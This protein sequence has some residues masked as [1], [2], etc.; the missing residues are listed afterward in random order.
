MKSTIYQ[1]TKLRHNRSSLEKLS[2]LATHIKPC[3]Y[4][5][6]KRPGKTCKRQGTLCT[7][8]SYRPTSMWTHKRQRHSSYRQRT[9]FYKKMTG[10]GVMESLDNI[11]SAR[12]TMS[13]GAILQLCSHIQS[14]KY[15]KTNRVLS[16]SLSQTFPNSTCKRAVRLVWETLAWRSSTWE[17]VPDLPFKLPPLRQKEWNGETRTTETKSACDI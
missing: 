12:Q 10:R 5:S 17:M 7:R 14:S 2:T 13:S 9:S 15:S 8:V 3:T 6:K 16:V 11:F 1:S 4:P